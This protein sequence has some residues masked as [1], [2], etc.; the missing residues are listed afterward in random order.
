MH[1]R[2]LPDRRLRHALPTLA[3][4]VALL[5][6]ASAPAVAPAAP[7]ASAAASPTLKRGDRGPAVR[8]LQRLLGVRAD[9]VFGATTVRSLKRFQR[10]HRMRVDGVAGPATWR[11]LRRARAGQRA[12]RGR[13][14]GSSA[15]AL[16]RVQR[17]LGLAADGIFGPG[18]AR[19]VRAFQ[20]RHGL[21]ADG[22]VGAATYRALGMRP[23]P[24]LHP[25]SAR[26]R[27]IGRGGGNWRIRAMVRAANRIAHHPYKWGGGHG[28]WTD[29]GYDCSGAVSY[30]L[31]AAGL[32]SA[33][34]TAD[35]F[36]QYGVRGRGR[37][38][39]IYANGGHVFMVI[40][41]RRFDS[42]G[43]D[44]SG[45]FWQPRMRDTGSFVARHPAGL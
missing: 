34:R 37:R 17:R 28:Q 11:V 35:V 25:R 12:R 16:R 33:S 2:D 45:S 14:G 5:G 29:S 39:T 32:L 10:R 21:T 24:T 13:T 1:R 43:R 44:S 27:R 20:R 23:G 9:G 22:V 41:G 6:A 40:D 18:T 8:S 4:A 19:A 26:G 42:T 30:V 15:V 7:R 38:V 36:M 3:A 31:H